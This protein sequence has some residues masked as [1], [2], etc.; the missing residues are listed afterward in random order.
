MGALQGAYAGFQIGDRISQRK[1]EKQERQKQERYEKEAQTILSKGT[2]EKKDYQK[3]IAIGKGDM[4]KVT[5]DIH[6]SMKNQRLADQRRAAFRV[7]KASYSAGMLATNLLK[8]PQ[9]ERMGHFEQIVAAGQ[10]NPET[11]ELLKNVGHMLSS[12]QGLDFSDG[13]LKALQQ[14]AS[15]GVLHSTAMDQDLSNSLYAHLKGAIKNQADRAKIDSILEGAIAENRNLTIGEEFSLASVVDPTKINEVRKTIAEAGFI[16]A[17]AEAQRATAANT[18]TQTEYLQGTIEAGGPQAD[19]AAVQ[20]QNVERMSAAEVNKA[21]AAGTRMDTNLKQATLEA[22]GPQADVDAV[23]AASD[24]NRSAAEVNR[25]TAKKTSAEAAKIILASKH[26]EEN[27]EI[28]KKSLEQVR[29][30]GGVFTAENIQTVLPHM[31]EKTIE[32]IFKLYTQS[33]GLGGEF[34]QFPTKSSVSNASSPDALN[35]LSG[36]AGGGTQTSSGDEDSG[37]E[38]AVAGLFGNREEDSSSDERDPRK[39]EPRF[40]SAGPDPRQSQDEKKSTP[41]PDTTDDARAKRTGSAKPKP[42]E[43]DTR[44][45]IRRPWATPEGKTKTDDAS[46]GPDPRRSQDGKKSTPKPANP[47]E[48]DPRKANPRFAR[49][50]ST[51]KAADKPKPDPSRK[52]RGAG[53]VPDPYAALPVGAEGMMPAKGDKPKPDTTDDA[54]AKRTGAAKPKPKSKPTPVASDDKARRAQKPKPKK[55]KQTPVQFG[56]MGGAPRATSKP[57]TTDDARAKRTAAAK[58]KP[59]SKP[60]PVASDDKA[61]RAQKPKPKKAKQTPVQFGM[62][63]GAPRATSKPDTT[64]DARAKRTAAAKPKPKPKPKPDTTDDARA[65]RSGS[66]RP[67]AKS[68]TSAVDPKAHRDLIEDAIAQAKKVGTPEL[69]S[70]LKDLMPTPV[71]S[72]DKARRAQKPKPKKAKQT[73]VQF[74][75]MGGAPRATSKPDTTDDA[76]AK[77]TGAAK[78]KPKSKPTPVASDDK[79]RRAQKPK[80][81]KAK[82]TPVQ[83]GMM[84]GA[85]RATSKPDTTDDARAKRSGSLRPKA[86]SKT[87]AVDPKAHRDLISDA[88][89]QA[90]K[91][92]DPGLVSALNDLLPTP[93]ASDD[94]ARRGHSKKKLKLADPALGKPTLPKGKPRPTPMELEDRRNRIE[95]RYNDQ[96]KTLM[97][98]GLS[99]KMSQKILDRVFK[100]VYGRK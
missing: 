13:R 30:D 59:K 69:V 77:R 63:G 29:E 39:Q 60:T 95:K 33:D 16:D 43:G 90:Q 53:E 71:A 86:K 15:L 50:K 70:A 57:D 75:M 100:S 7:G 23:R 9:E 64:D 42:D 78:P 74:G 94:K 87:S 19:V 79:A 97:K 99:R 26:A 93:V 28:I 14:N 45:G 73:P 34:I 3:L 54:R 18:R 58:P 66:L 25:S 36:D 51:P 72:D 6:E 88:I 47:D 37:P 2:L 83:F 55:A 92:G 41:K 38:R 40:A 32:A 67:K 21:T 68:K 1:L 10:Q 89:S 48:K 76:R 91:L 20:A 12:E 56:M 8:L 4:A 35:A 61:R 31:D 22:G 96:L 80:P 24:V 46:V 65:K 49:Q 98:A 82:Q 5:W 52:P 62:M 81:K 85:P 44:Y 27:R 84:G 11:K 17:Q